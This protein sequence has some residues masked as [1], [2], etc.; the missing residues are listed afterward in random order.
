[1]IENELKDLI[2]ERYGSLTAF[3]DKIG[4]PY[5]TIDSILRRGIGKANLNNIMIMCEELQIS[6]DGLKHN[7]IIPITFQKLTRQ[8]LARQTKYLI[9]DNQELS[10]KQKQH[11]ILSIELSCLDDDSK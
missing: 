4:L 1:M 11:L 6:I 8:E 9:A 3:T 10:D 7:R 2:I 5:S